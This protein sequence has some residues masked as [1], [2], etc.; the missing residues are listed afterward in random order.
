MAKIFYI[1]LQLLT[2]IRDKVVRKGFKHSSLT[3]DNF[4]FSK[5]AF[6][7]T[8]DHF[9]FATVTAKQSGPARGGIIGFDDDH[10]SVIG[11]LEEL[12]SFSLNTTTAQ[13]TL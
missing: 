13:M 7:V 4:G 2:E 10:Q 11:M 6:Q 8:L 3:L 12:I 9:P 5:H 1:A